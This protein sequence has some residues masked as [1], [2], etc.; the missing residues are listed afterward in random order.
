MKYSNLSIRARLF[1]GNGITVSILLVLCIVVWSSINTLNKTAAMVEHTY[2]VIDESNGLVNAM[3]D[4][5][6]G[7]RGFAVGGQED[8]LEP[9]FAGKKQFNLYLEDVKNLTS[10]NPAQQERF[11]IVAEDADHWQAYAEKM[12][13][14]RK[15]IVKGESTNN[16]LTDLIQSGVGKQKMDGLRA[17][18][19]NGNFGLKG[20]VLLGAMIN[21]ETG[22]RGFMLN[23]EEEFLEPFNA[24]QASV[25]QILP[26][27]QGSNLAKNV[28]GWIEDYANNAISLVREANKF[29]SM[30]TLYNEFSKKQGKAYMDDLREKVA[31][32][33]AEEERLMALRKEAA[34]EASSL[35]IYVVLFGGFIAILLSLT[36]GIIISNSITNPIGRAVE[37]ANQ[38]A[39]GDLTVQ[40]DA[41][42]ND[43]V[44]KLL[45]ALQ[46]TV[47]SLKNIMGNI[48]DASTRLGGASGHLSSVTKNTSV[49]AREQLQMTD[50][51]ATAMHEMATTVQE[52][53]RSA[54]AAA[55][56][57]NEANDEAKT[58]IEVS[59]ST[60]ETIS[61]LEGEI[62][63]TST[64]LTSLAD[65]ANNIGGILD[66][67]RGIADQTNLL[68]L[69]AA[70]E[71]ARAGEQGRGFA[72]V[73]DEVRSLAK[74]TQESTEEIQGLIERLQKGT[75]EAVV[76]MDRSR[77]FVE[78]SVKEA[79]RSGQVLDSISQAIDKI[80]DM[81][82]QIASSS[83]QQ[84][85]TAE[86]INQNVVT[87]KGI[88][89]KSATDADTSVESSNELAEISDT[90]RN[91][92]GKFKIA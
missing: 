53:A 72:V 50:L 48:S 75:G 20:E 41:K 26:S 73:A 84:R 55:E 21:M 83:E 2:K 46:L 49:G 25:K 3:V 18:I 57:A 47:T 85:E 63:Q 10:D 51:V 37:M 69:N 59:K 64:K 80:N 88:S 82:S 70:I 44:S 19:A 38:I 42:G 66:V 27:I 81:N 17:D 12:I 14:L 58:G 92:V 67:I 6:T 40:V 36:I 65:E 1:I 62:T 86:S 31:V 32:I 4:Q 23:R 16:T 71:A 8:Y 90:L 54:G 87:V 74:R 61:K 28:N 9:Y 56:S 11:D 91:I 52:V 39:K 30:D 77:S 35:V 89:E 45:G 22:L 78:S 33:V 29:Q 34:T 5:E 76:T 60:I 13:A 24:G 15:D 43:E 68:A 79:E 7:L